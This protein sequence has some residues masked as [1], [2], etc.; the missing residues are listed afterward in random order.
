MFHY[1]QVSIAVH[2]AVA[3]SKEYKWFFLLTFTLFSHHTLAFHPF[4]SFVSPRKKLFGDEYARL[5]QT[6]PSILSTGFE[7]LFHSPK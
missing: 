6:A 2:Y 4:L 7:G 1:L 3:I 5:G